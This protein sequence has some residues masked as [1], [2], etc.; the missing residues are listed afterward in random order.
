MSDLTEVFKTIDLLIKSCEIDYLEL[1]KHKIDEMFFADYGNQR[2]INSFLFNFIKIQDK[3]GAKLFKKV[4]Y[5]QKEIDDE[6]L[7][8]KDV[9]NLL[10]KLR[11]LDNSDNWEKLREIR[12]ALTHEYP[13]DVQERIENIILA[14]DGYNT[15]KMIYQNLKNYC[16]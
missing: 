14:I 10:E 11:I 5:S 9:L 2:V 1:K 13:F 16:Q 3:I 7:P 4:L 8:M 6:S 12:N 15:L